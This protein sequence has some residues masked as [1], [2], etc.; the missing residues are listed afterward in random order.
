MK[1][2]KERIKIQIKP[3]TS[4]TKSNNQKQVRYVNGVKTY[5]KAGAWYCD[6]NYYQQAKEQQ[7]I[8]ANEDVF[9]SWCEKWDLS[10]T[11]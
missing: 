1:E 7:G 4:K 3:Q 10:P 8:R 5:Y 6:W 11:G 2:R 9:C